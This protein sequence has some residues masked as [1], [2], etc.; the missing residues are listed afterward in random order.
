MNRALIILYKRQGLTNI[1]EQEVCMSDTPPVS[2]M[3]LINDLKATRLYYPRVQTRQTRRKPDRA[4]REVVLNFRAEVDR[5][6]L[7]ITFNKA[8]AW[9]SRNCMLSVSS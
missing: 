2:P 6:Q 3:Q 9:T 7:T 4:S 8:Q 5:P 1:L